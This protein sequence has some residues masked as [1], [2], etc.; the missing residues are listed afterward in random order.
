MKIPIE[1]TGSNIIPLWL[2]LS[3]KDPPGSGL[4]MNSNPSAI[5]AVVPFAKGSASGNQGNETGDDATTSNAQNS[6]SIN[7]Q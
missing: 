5:N 7:L 6:A 3:T 2:A 1:E 4:L